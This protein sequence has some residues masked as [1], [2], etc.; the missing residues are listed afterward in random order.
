MWDFFFFVSWHWFHLFQGDV[1]SNSCSFGEGGVGVVGWGGK[2]FMFKDHAFVTLTVSQT[3]LVFTWLQDSY[4]WRTHVQDAG[5][6]VN[7]PVPFR[8]KAGSDAERKVA[9]SLKDT[10]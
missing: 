7:I 3:V 1:G 2:G 6:K 8:F 9:M 5:R 10:A 4:K